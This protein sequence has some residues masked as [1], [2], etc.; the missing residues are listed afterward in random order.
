MAGDIAGPYA[1][2]RLG[3]G[4]SQISAENQNRQDMQPASRHASDSAFAAG[5]FGGYWL[6]SSWGVE[7]AL[8]YLGAQAT[9][10]NS[11]FSSTETVELPVLSVAATGRWLLNERIGV[12]A[13]LGYAYIP[14]RHVT[15]GWGPGTSINSAGEAVLN[16]IA[17]TSSAKTVNNVVPQLGIAVDWKINPYIRAQ[18]GYEYF[19]D[20]YYDTNSKLN[21]SL[22][23]LGVYY[24][25]GQ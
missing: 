4:H 13:K 23:S 12:S 24:Q 14:A 7:G 2:A 3:V 16:T 17:R 21:A 19:P 9:G 6:T 18:L 11:G 5:F 10:N 1:G 25:F 15:E 20:V 22:L 8:G